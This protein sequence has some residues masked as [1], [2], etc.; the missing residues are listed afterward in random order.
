M[1]AHEHLRGGGP[2]LVH[3]AP[4][5]GVTARILVVIL[6]VLPDRHHLHTLFDPHPHDFPVRLHARRGTRRLGRFSP[7]RRQRGVVR[8]RTGCV[9][10]ALRLCPF[11][12]LAHGCARHLQVLGY[13]PLTLASAQTIDQFSQVIHVH[14][15]HVVCPPDSIF[16]LP[17]WRHDATIVFSA[18]SVAYIKR[19]SSPGF[20]VKRA[21]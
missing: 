13:A 20:P 12:V 14:S 18:Q 17:L 1:H 21:A 8:Q 3:E 11:L 6:Q 7:C 2:Q 5:R 10:V 9:Q 4:Y 19:R 15:L 16:E